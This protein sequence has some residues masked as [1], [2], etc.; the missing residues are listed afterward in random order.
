MPGSQGVQK[1][2]FSLSPYFPK[3]QVS[4]DMAPGFAVSPA[5][6]L[7]HRVGSANVLKR[8]QLIHK[9][10]AVPGKVKAVQICEAVL[11]GLL[12]FFEL[13]VLRQIDA[14]CCQCL[15]HSRE[16]AERVRQFSDLDEQ[17]SH[18]RRVLAFGRCLLHSAT[19]EPG[20][21]FEIVFQLEEP[22]SARAGLAV[23]L[24]LTQGFSDAVDV[25]KTIRR[26]LTTLATSLL[27]Q[28]GAEIVAEQCLVDFEHKGSALL[29]D[30]QQGGFFG[31]GAQ[32]FAGKGARTV[33]SEAARVCG[34]FGRQAVLA[35]AQDGVEHDM[36]HFRVAACGGLL[37]KS[38]SMGGPIRDEAS[39]GI[40][41]TALRSSSFA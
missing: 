11:Q 39:G 9:S 32:P 38:Q 35:I 26:V 34:R 7:S 30:D 27:V 2:G 36:G 12:H 14:R 16:L 22:F 17:G 33:Q 8:F 18:K 4:Q 25:R 23:E 1:P 37:S 29:C 13:I 28:A 15:L 41:T 31:Q 19:F 24:C 20:Q 40:G 5:S 21:D 3:S 10:I 6:Q